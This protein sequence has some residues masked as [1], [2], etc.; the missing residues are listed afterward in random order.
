[1]LQAGSFLLQT[2]LRDAL[3]QCKTV[4][5]FSALADSARVQRQSEPTFYHSCRWDDGEGFASH[6]G[7]P[8]ISYF[9]CGRCAS[10]F[11]L[12]TE[13]CPPNLNFPV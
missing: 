4:I 5:Q 12:R 13:L 11:A 8:L 6:S 10:P 7:I 2:R 3:L 9:P 1:M